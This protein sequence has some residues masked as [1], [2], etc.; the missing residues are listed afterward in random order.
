MKIL[1]KFKSKKRKEQ[2]KRKNIS[3]PTIHVIVKRLMGNM[4]ITI[5]EFDAILDRDDDFNQKI[6]NEEYH[7]KEDIDV[8][9]HKII[10][11][12][13][14]K[15]D[16]ENL[17]A[18]NPADL[19][20]KKLE[21]IDK[22]IAEQENI[23]KTIKFSSTEVQGIE[24]DPDKDEG[25]STGN[26][27]DEDYKLQQLKALRFVVQRE[28]E[29]VYEEVN[30]NGTRQMMFLQKEGVFYPYYHCS[31]NVTLYPDIGSK[32]KVYKERQAMIDADYIDEN[33]NPFSG[34]WK[35]V[36][37][38]MLIIVFLLNV[39]WSMELSKDRQEFSNMVDSSMFGQILEKAE[40]SYI[41]CADIYTELI[42]TNKEFINIGKN[43]TFENINPNQ[44]TNVNLG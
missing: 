26:I 18:D 30:A 21:A 24:V 42:E 32:R 2:D 25:E 1:D 34:I 27:I 3:K 10:E 37:W 35:N 5:A 43:K 9:A 31:T 20:A 44:G 22:K 36:L 7:F 41:K 15:L 8:S 28:G 11:L 14:Y 39:Y 33:R 40:G 23:V 38:I 6:I 29:G 12:L 16:L 17:K 13:K 4:P 19:K